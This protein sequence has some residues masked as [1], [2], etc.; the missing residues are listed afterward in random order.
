[1]TWNRRAGWA[2][3]L[4]FLLAGCGGNGIEHG[5]ENQPKAKPLTQSDFFAD[6]RASRLPVPGTV[7]HGHAKADD[8]LYTGKINGKDADIFPFPVTREVLQRGHERFDIFCAVCHDRAGTGNGMIVRRGFKQPP[9]YHSEALRK[10]PVGHFYDVVANGFGTMYPYA[11]RIS[12]Q[13]RWAIV[14]Y[15]RAL[16][17]S[18]NARWDDVPEADRAAL[19]KAQP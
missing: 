2:V 10:A 14:A 19:A 3:G 16:Q 8:L 15:I 13:D 18:Q 5:M 1:M 7:P 9:S 12:V 11:D 4:A 17:L 6:Q